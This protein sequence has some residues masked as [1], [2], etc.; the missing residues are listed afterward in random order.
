MRLALREALAAILVPS[1]ATMPTW[2]SPAWAHSMSTSVNSP[3]TA[4]SWS[5]RNRLI[6]EWSGARLAQITRLAIS[7]WQARAIW[8]DERTPM[9]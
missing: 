1:M 7:V 9:L 3:A 4:A 6:V 8:R 2:H 5:A